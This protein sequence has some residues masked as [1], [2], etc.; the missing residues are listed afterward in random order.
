MPIII[1]PEHRKRAAIRTLLS[2]RLGSYPPLSEREKELGDQI[3]KFLQS[4]CLQTEGIPLLVAWGLS[5]KEDLTEREIS[6]VEGLLQIF[7]GDPLPRLVIKEKIENSLKAWKRQIGPLQDF[8]ETLL[9]E[10]EYLSQLLEIRDK[11]KA[12]QE[13]IQTLQHHLSELSQEETELLLILTNPDKIS[14]KPVRELEQPE[15][16]PEPELEQLVLEPLP[17]STNWAFE[18]DPDSAPDSLQYC[19]FPNWR[20]RMGRRI[21]HLLNPTNKRET[22]CRLSIKETSEIS[23][24]LPDTGTVCLTCLRKKG[25]SQYPLD[26]DLK[27][28]S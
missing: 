28:G 24:N 18:L 1:K 17:K 22:F 3:E 8:E 23:Q 25:P 2:K 21:F 13:K 9:Q 12:L 10:K 27:V 4:E 20:V 15:P 14:Q 6:F 7:K 5:S 11:K 16:E 26:K 19:G